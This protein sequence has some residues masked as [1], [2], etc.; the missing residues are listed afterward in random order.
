MD[1]VMNA[2]LMPSRTITNAAGSHAFALQW[3]GPLVVHAKTGA[4]AVGGERVSWLVGYVSSKNRE[5]VFASR[6]RARADLPG[7]PGADLALRVLNARAP[8]GR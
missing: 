4:A 3:P 6:V 5:Y 8:S 1:A 2:F 7:T